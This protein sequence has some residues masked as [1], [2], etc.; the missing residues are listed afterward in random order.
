MLQRL[1]AK[2]NAAHLSNVEVV[3]AG[4]LTYA[5]RGRPADFVYSRFAP[6]HLP[7]FW[8]A[9]VAYATSKARRINESVGESVCQPGLHRSLSSGCYRR[10]DL[11]SS[12]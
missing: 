8:K 12:T 7:D 4:F 5:H 1:R 11:V 10:S 9:V 3:Q 2:I 6:H